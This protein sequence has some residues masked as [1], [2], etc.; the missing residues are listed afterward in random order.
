M[1]RMQH[2]TMAIFVWMRRAMYTSFGTNFQ[3]YS[4]L[5]DDGITQSILILASVLLV[6]VA[7]L[8]QSGFVLYKW[9]AILFVTLYF[10]YIGFSIAQ[11]FL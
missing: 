8:L 4:G 11:V 2:L 10:A 3:P 9:H 6:F 7:L 5:T 1:R